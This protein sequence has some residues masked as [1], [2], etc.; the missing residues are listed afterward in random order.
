M[1]LILAILDKGNS[2][3]S[4]CNPLGSFLRA[5]K[6]ST[7]NKPISKPRRLIAV[8]VRVYERKAAVNKKNV[9]CLSVETQNKQN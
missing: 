7:S 3:R 5:V 6:L 2:F 4:F 9:N 1:K 8:D